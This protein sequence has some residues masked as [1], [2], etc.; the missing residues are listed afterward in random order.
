[1]N[2]KQKGSRGERECR[3][4]TQKWVAVIRNNYKKIYLGNYKEKEAA[5]KARKEA[6]KIYMGEFAYEQG[7]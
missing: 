2:S 3:K 7:E 4:D 6:E 1:M 5:I